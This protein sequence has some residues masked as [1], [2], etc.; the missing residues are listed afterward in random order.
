MKSDKALNPIIGT[1]LIIAI[2]IIVAATI[3]VFIFGGPEN[4]SEYTVKIVN[5]TITNVTVLP[6]RFGYSSEYRLSFSNGD[7]L[8]FG[9]PGDV[10]IGGSLPRT[11]FEKLFLDNHSYMMTYKK[12]SSEEIRWTLTNVTEVIFNK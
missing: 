6:E 7:L 10:L 9:G 5:V 8:T 11:G 2:I 1:I 4:T 3:A 12:S